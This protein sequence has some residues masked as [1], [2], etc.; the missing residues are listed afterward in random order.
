MTPEG[1]K[2]QERFEELRLEQEFERHNEQQ[3]SEWL[4]NEEFKRRNKK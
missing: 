2:Q 3:F 4:D 1:K